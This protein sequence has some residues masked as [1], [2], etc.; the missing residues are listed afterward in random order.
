MK[1]FVDIEDLIFSP[2]QLGCGLYLPGLPGGG[3]KIYDRSPY[4]N[5]GAITGAVWKRLP[6]GLW[7]L[8]FDGTD[9]EIQVTEHASLKPATDSWTI[10]LWFNTSVNARQIMVE[11]WGATDGYYFD[12]YDQTQLHFTIRNAGSIDS[13]TADTQN[14]HDGKWHQAVAV[15]NESDGKLYIFL[16]GKSD[17]TPVAATNTTGQDVSPSADLIIG[18]SGAFDVD[19]GLALIQMCRTAWTALEVRNSFNRE[20]YLFGVWSR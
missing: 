11:M 17:A 6:S 5:H 18:E 14:L 3:S 16:D 15:R 10:K 12:V 20:K 8:D 4:G 9:D 13:V 7:Y 1:T 2:P 19:G